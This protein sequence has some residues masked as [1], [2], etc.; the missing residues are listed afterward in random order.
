VE[1]L[2]GMV[3]DYGIV[4]TPM[5]HYLVTCHNT[6]GSYGRPTHEGYFD[7]LAVAFKALRAEVSL[8]LDTVIVEFKMPL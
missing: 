1:V 4:T 5:L 8:I 2:G 6:G 7:K 3:T